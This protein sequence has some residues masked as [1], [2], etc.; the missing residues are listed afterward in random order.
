MEDWQKKEVE[1]CLKFMGKVRNMPDKWEVEYMDVDNRSL[2]KATI[3]INNI[4]VRKLSNNIPNF[5]VVLYGETK[6]D[7][8]AKM[9]PENL[10][11]VFF[12]EELLVCPIDNDIVPLHELCT[13]E[14]ERNMLREYKIYNKYML[15]RIR[16]SDIITRWYGWEL[17]D[18]IR[19]IR[20]SDPDNPYYRIVA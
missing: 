2:M 20:R 1:K 16:L 8:L 13:K 11:R 19:I 12:V 10:S 3:A 18:V 7:I 9:T 14:E 15:P 6:H 17:G 5:I 4:I